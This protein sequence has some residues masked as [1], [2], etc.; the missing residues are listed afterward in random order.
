MIKIKAECK[1]FSHDQWLVMLLVVGFAF[2]LVFAL[3]PLRV[4]LT[5][6]E[7]DAW[8]VTAIA[9]NV[10]LGNGISAD[11]VHSTNGFHPLYPLTLSL[12]P[13]LVAPN[14]LV[15][16]FTANLVICAVLNTMIIIPLTLL[17]RQFVPLWAVRI[18]VALFSLNTYLVRLSVNAMETSLALLVLIIFVLCLTTTSKNSI[19]QA[20]LLGSIMGLS[21]LS[22]LDNGLMGMVVGIVWIMV[23]L[24]QRKGLQYPIIYGLTTIGIL[25][26]Y[27]I[28]NLT[29]FGSFFPS[30]G[31]ALA[32]LHSYEDSFRLTSIVQFIPYNSLVNM[33]FISSNLILC[34][35]AIIVFITLVWVSIRSKNYQQTLISITLYIFSLTFYYAYIQ[36]QGNPRYYVGVSTLLIVPIMLLLV[37]ITT[38]W[39]SRILNTVLAAL[40]LVVIVTNSGEAI[41]RYQHVSQATFL[42][43]PTMYETALW[44]AQNLPPDTKIAARNSG[45]LQY[46]SDRFVLN[47]DGK[48]N[49]EIIPV[50][51][52]RELLM[53]LKEN[54][55]EYIIDLYDV[56]E[57]IEFYSKELTDAPAHREISIIQRINIYVKLIALKIGIP[58][59]SVQ[60]EKREIT[61]LIKPFT[62]VAPI[63]R[64]FPRP[65]DSSNPITIF[66]MKP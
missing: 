7:D 40:G 15:F 49:H 8:M 55:I 20:S 61:H 19:R 12:L 13:Y 21:I 65:F 33:N 23:N 46:Y 63:W 11:G 36:Q 52:K 6:L 9:R 24:Y 2:R 54:Q 26:P 59:T 35:L 32:Y 43:Q 14:N 4:H 30:S 5:L 64:V 48:L 38:V 66:R 29:V 17:L 10:A 58:T 31:K 37:R 27:F 44:I 39:S 16:G 60:L 1:F 47:I 3:M 22:R 42:S 50:L 18:G 25:I 57:Y 56:N 45:I 28:R 53:Y 41:L 62:D 51:E 34:L